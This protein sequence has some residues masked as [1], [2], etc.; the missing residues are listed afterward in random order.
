MSVGN[1]IFVGGIHGV[2]KTE[3]SRALCAAT[4]LVH[5]TASSLI[6]AQKDK[7]VKN[8][9]KNQDILIRAIR[10]DLRESERYLMDGHF[11]LLNSNNQAEEIQLNVF[12][13]IGMAGIFILHAD[14][15]VIQERLR[16]RD[17]KEYPI[18]ILSALQEAELAHGAYIAKS[19]SLPLRIIADA[20][21]SDSSEHARFIRNIFS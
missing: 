18:E 21:E 4:S 10:T 2:G 6:G 7:Q 3:F 1:I 12:H 16:N 14:V 15:L 5:I 19:L 13:Q 17:S 9:S 20:S 11:C 8:I